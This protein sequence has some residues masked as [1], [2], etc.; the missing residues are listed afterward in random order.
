MDN[1]EEIID[2][3]ISNSIPEADLRQ[4]NNE[5]RENSDNKSENVNDQISE[6]EDIPLDQKQ[7]DKPIL[8]DTI[9]CIYVLV[10]TKL[11]W[12]IHHPWF[13][14]IVPAMFTL[15]IIP[16]LLTAYNAYIEEEKEIQA[17]IQQIYIN[18]EAGNHSE[19]E[20]DIYKIYPKLQKKNDYETLLSLSD[21]LL[22]SIYQEFYQTQTALSENKKDLLYSYANNALGYAEK[23]KDTTYYI[24]ICIHMALFNISEYQF[25]LNTKYLDNADIALNA[26]AEYF[27]KNH[28]SE[29]IITDKGEANLACQFFNLKNLQYQVSYYRAVIGYPFDDSI[30]KMDQSVTSESEIE[31]EESY[32]TFDNLL[33]TTTQFISCV[34]IIEDQNK[35]TG[36]I[37]D[38]L[39]QHMKVL[40]GTSY[41]E[42]GNLLFNF[43][44]MLPLLLSGGADGGSYYIYDSIDFCIDLF[45]K[46]E[47]ASIEIKNY[48]DLVKVYKSAETYFYLKYVSNGSNDSLIKYNEFIE[49]LLELDPSGEILTPYTFETGNGIVLDKY[50]E[51]AE[52]K[53]TDITLGNDPL[54]FSL[55]KYKLG[56]HYLTRALYCDDIGDYEN[57]KMDFENADRC[58]TSALLY[59]NK[60]H[61][62]IF[63]E[64]TRNQALISEML[65]RLNE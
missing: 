43:G 1:K 37:S 52:R 29:I 47:D 32:S 38:D 54:G 45:R 62:G 19:M 34:H 36:L 26:A 57:A 61:A 58:Y 6:T 17:T 25:T 21:M 33:W 20:Q 23:L 51:N 13:K 64:I 15:F 56:T 5:T 53:L 48:E 27:D 14:K 42:T 40:A 31:F 65:S 63:D 41:I 55:L 35:S 60:E 9:K 22:G 12:I 16:Q 59:F 30:S 8:R 4:C 46:L 10:K 2:S 44:G 24:K 49:K 7:K 50:I 3:Q 18:Y 11:A 28:A 39:I